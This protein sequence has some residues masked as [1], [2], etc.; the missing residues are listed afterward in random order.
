MTADIFKAFD[1]YRRSPALVIWHPLCVSIGA[2]ARGVFARTPPAA[3]AALAAAAAQKSADAAKIEKKTPIDLGDT[4]SLKRALDDC[5][6][7]V[8]AKGLEVLLPP[9]SFRK[10]FYETSFLL[11]QVITDSGYGEDHFVSNVKIGLGTLTCAAL[12]YTAHCAAEFLPR[13]K[14]FPS[15]TIPC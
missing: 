2:M 12:S 10:P 4:A 5:V 13:G 11:L 1:V 7:Q 3:G 14:N 15:N 8:T 9:K 6:L